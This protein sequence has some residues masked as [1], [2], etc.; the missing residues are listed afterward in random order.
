MSSIFVRA[1]LTP[2]A[3]REAE[4]DAIVEQF[5]KAVAEG[6]PGTRGFG[7]YRDAGG[8]Y[9]VIEHYESADAVVAHVANVGH[10][11][12]PLGE[13]VATSEPLEVHGEANEEIRELWAAFDPV[14]LPTVAAI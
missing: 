2:K 11:F 7:W 6:E 8:A 9:V 10:L 3:G 4:F 13:L 5:V 1:K 12:A 14:F